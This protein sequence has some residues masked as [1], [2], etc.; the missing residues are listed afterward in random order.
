[1][2]LRIS[3]EEGRE[4]RGLGLDGEVRGDDGAARLPHGAADTRRGISDSRVTNAEIIR[5]S[6]RYPP[7]WK[8]LFYLHFERHKTI[9]LVR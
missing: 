2:P 3:G 7:C 6:S 4:A 8:L 9:L 5:I 1:M